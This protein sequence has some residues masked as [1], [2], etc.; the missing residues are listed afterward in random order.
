MNM[1]VLGGTITVEV[2]LTLVLLLIDVG[3]GRKGADPK[4]D[5][6]LLDPA[7][8]DMSFLDMKSIPKSMLHSISSQTTIHECS[9]RAPAMVSVRSI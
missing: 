3:G 9:T 8:M 1:T 4:G 7:C 2:A 6:I 5:V